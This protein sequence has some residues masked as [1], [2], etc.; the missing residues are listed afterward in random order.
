MYNYTYRNLDGPT[1]FDHSLPLAHIF[2]HERATL[3]KPEI[4]L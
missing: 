2:I 1:M 4:L 3:G